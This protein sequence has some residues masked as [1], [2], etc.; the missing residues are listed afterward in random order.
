MQII[1]IS[2]LKGGCAKTTT[3]V[4]L[5]A[6]LAQAGR[7]VLLIDLD[8]QGNASEWLGVGQPSLGSLELFTTDHALDAFIHASSVPGVS[9]IAGSGALS[10]LDRI[11]TSTDSPETQLKTRLSK[12][13][14]QQWDDVILDT[15]PTLS[16]LTLNALTAA[17]QLLIPVTTQVLSLSGVAQ[18]MQTFDVIREDFNPKLELLGL[19][20]SRVNLRTLHAQ[21]IIQALSDSFGEKLLKTHI[22]E[23]IRLSEAPSFKQSIFQYSPKSGACDDFRSLAREVLT[24]TR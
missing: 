21:D 15:P 10:G 11:L 6:G 8:P 22:R 9:V 16:L 14:K 7:K 1:A 12:L 24:L 13:R 17:H 3:S 2:N 5:A 20:A 4:N 18:L 19:V 23:N